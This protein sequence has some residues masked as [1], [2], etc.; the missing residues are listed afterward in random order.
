MEDNHPTSQRRGSITSEADVEGILRSSMSSSPNAEVSS[1]MFDGLEK[2]VNRPTQ[3]ESDVVSS[4]AP[5]LPQSGT[6]TP[7][8]PTHQSSTSVACETSETQGIV[9]SVSS[10]SPS[11]T[12]PSS[13]TSGATPAATPATTEDKT[14]SVPADVTNSGPLT[15]STNLED[16]SVQNL[17]P[18]HTNAEEGNGGSASENNAELNVPAPPDSSLGLRRFEDND[19]IDLS[20]P[21]E[22][23]AAAIEACLDECSEFQGSH[24]YARTFSEAPNPGL[25]LLPDSELGRIGLPLNEREARRIWSQCLGTET[26]Q[27]FAGVLE[28]RADGVRID[29]PAWVG[30]MEAIR[31][32]S[33]YCSSVRARGGWDD[34]E[35][36]T[37]AQT[38]YCPFPPDT[39]SSYQFEVQ[40]T[41]DAVHSPNPYFSSV[42]VTLPS[43]HIGG[44][45]QINYGAAVT[46]YD[47]SPPSYLAT[48]VLAWYS[49][50][51]DVRL[52]GVV[53]IS[54][55]FRLALRYTLVH[56]DPAKPIPCLPSPTAQTAALKHAL[57]S[58]K[59]EGWAGLQKIVCLLSGHY[60]VENLA[61]VGL[62][63]MVTAPQ[64]LRKIE[65]VEAVA[66]EC[67][68][69]VGLAT[70]ETVIEGTPDYQ[71]RYD[72]WDEDGEYE[73][74]SYNS[75]YEDYARPETPDP[76]PSEYTMG[77]VNSKETSC[78]T[79]VDIR[80]G[81]VIAEE[82]DDV[83][84]DVAEHIPE[85]MLDD[86][87]SDEPD[88][89][90]Y[91]GWKGNGSGS[92]TRSY[93]GT[94]LVIWPA[95][96]H[97]ELTEG[98]EYVEGQAFEILEQGDT[99]NPDQKQ[100]DCVEC[101][102]EYARYQQHWSS[103]PRILSTLSRAASRWDNRELFERAMKRCHGEEKVR[104]LGCEGILDALAKF[105]IDY[106]KP[107]IERI[108]QND[109][110]NSDRLQ[111]LESLR[112]HL[113]SEHPELATW[114]DERQKAVLEN[115]APLAKPDIAPIFAYLRE[116]GDLSTFSRTISPLVNKFTPTDAVFD[117]ATLLHQETRLNAGSGIL[118][119]TQDVATA[120][121][122]VL[123]LLARG[124][125]NSDY[126]DNPKDHTI[127]LEQR[128]LELALGHIKTCLAMG[129][130]GG[131]EAVLKKLSPERFSNGQWGRS[132][133]IARYASTILPLLPQFEPLLGILYEGRVTLRPGGAAFYRSLTVWYAKGLEYLRS[134]RPITGELLKLVQMAV[135]AG[136]LGAL[137]ES[138]V[139]AL[140]N[141]V[142]DDAAIKAFVRN[143]HSRRLFLATSPQTGQSLDKMIGD[144]LRVMISRN[145]RSNSTFT[146]LVEWIDLCL[147]VQNLG[148]CSEILGRMQSESQRMDKNAISNVLLPLVPEVW[149]RA[150]S[151]S[152][153][154]YGPE[155][156]PLAMKTAQIVGTCV[157]KALGYAEV[158]LL[159]TEL[160]RC[161][162][163]QCKSCRLV[164]QVLPLR[165]ERQEMI[166]RTLGVT[167]G[168]HVDQQ[169]RRCRALAICQW[170]LP[171][172][173]GDFTLK[174]QDGFYKASA[175]WKQARDNVL[176]LLRTVPGVDMFWF[177]IL[178]DSVYRSLLLNLDV[179]SIDH[180]APLNTSTIP[181]AGPS[182]SVASSAPKRPYS[183]I[184]ST[185]Q[186]QAAP[187]TPRQNNSA[188][189]RPRLS[190]NE[191]I[192]I[193]DLTSP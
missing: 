156:H 129:F 90:E 47:P 122:L 153:N 23:I 95:F 166:F 54:A 165:L 13:P 5:D 191:N 4:L 177:R 115:L 10:G 26:T 81:E 14:I 170:N 111:L 112:V 128:Y 39:Y 3:M 91:G 30:F 181:N 88:D 104:R 167:E 49:S 36:E 158:S 84:E 135:D 142:R 113:G 75:D 116:H 152:F 176:K 139:P 133:E 118:K 50:S 74:S 77:E 70:L 60:D 11:A 144:M 175:K 24:M 154:L 171:G 56:T 8:E 114:I 192:T 40:P 134:D 53:P 146:S 7:S 41:P 174:M 155:A 31:R 59:R 100:L 52:Q 189:K 12:G 117:L 119:T 126:F 83:G 184:Q 110:S 2:Q 22:D 137:E 182:A 178:G 42:L 186:P 80:T 169:L 32:E 89:E 66:R 150:A 190:N 64:D 101:L 180:R 138:V 141:H 69:N 92:L 6:A 44:I 46:L 124:I 99:C 37:F 96:R 62:R 17:A 79:L 93:R 105:G 48:S 185:S 125:S 1:T 145:V 160:R 58:W 109:T 187:Q 102:L 68:F 73:P 106:M 34:T 9:H 140:V 98:R 85:S 107:V 57:L 120:G 20:D 131:V 179:S 130:E 162:R 151:R 121:H 164:A 15:P 55:G 35:S 148:A 127:K 136:S 86:L 159:S 72:N 51:P 38:D 61:D 157:E 71:G 143:L 103:D 97:E 183:Q 188:A 65:F 78:I 63:G 163:Y 172:R 67:G 147:D 168:R 87:E 193:I 16:L 123:K 76:T 173:A 94:V 161:P 132:Q 108:L 149:T 27:P 82:L 19:A 45:T 18:M 21:C 25:R 33:P 43:P 29:N 28:T